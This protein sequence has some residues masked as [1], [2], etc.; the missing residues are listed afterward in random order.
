MTA[1]IRVIKWNCTN[2]GLQR[3][4]GYNLK[5]GY[6]RSPECT[7]S[8]DAIVAFTQ[9]KNQVTFPL[10]S[11]NGTTFTYIPKSTSNPRLI[12]VVLDNK[13]NFKA[14]SC[15][16]LHLR[17]EQGN[18]TF[19]HSDAY[20]VGSA[21]YSF[22][23]EIITVCSSTLCTGLLCNHCVTTTEQTS[24]PSS[25][26]SLTTSTS[27]TSKLTTTLSTHTTTQRTP[28]TVITHNNPVCGLKIAKSTSIK[29]V[30]S[31]EK[32]H[33]ERKQ[34]I[35]G[36]RKKN[37]WDLNTNTPNRNIE[38]NQGL[39]TNADKSGRSD[40]SKKVENVS[41]IGTESI[42]QDKTVPLRRQYDVSK[43][44]ITPNKKSK[45]KKM[46]KKM[47]KI[48]TINKKT[49]VTTLWEIIMNTT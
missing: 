16:D 3:C 29:P 34:S 40:Q 11:R 47:K 19:I 48:H 42:K 18:T 2:H 5:I 1:N 22:E 12:V 49:K 36:T 20:F 39:D 23:I 4:S 31:Q 43:L 32:D 8:T 41:T 9:N 24:E 10:S 7:L 35:T 25:T 13:D 45:G 44:E 46:K 17:Q 14:T 6:T 15:E 33:G 38:G 37:E 28:I 26:T 30:R 21:K 27:T